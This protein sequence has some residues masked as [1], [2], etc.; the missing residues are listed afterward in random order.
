MAFAWIPHRL[1]AV[2]GKKRPRS[3]ER[4]LLNNTQSRRGRSAFAALATLLS[5]LSGLLVLLA[6]LLTA[7][8]LLAGLLVLLARLLV[9]LARLLLATLLVLVRILLVL[10][11][12]TFFLPGYA[13]P[14]R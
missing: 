11:H 13:H 6:G 5:A 14:T 8:L 10:A 2:G 1:A 4:G 9:L 3:N 7:A 12:D